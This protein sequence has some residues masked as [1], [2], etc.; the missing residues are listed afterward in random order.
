MAL[1]IEVETRVGMMLINID[2]VDCISKST[3]TNEAII[4]FSTGPDEYIQTVETY[5]DVRGKIADVSKG[6]FENSNSEAHN[7]TG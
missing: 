7:G 5:Q 2:N 6:W 3:E 4:S 1:F